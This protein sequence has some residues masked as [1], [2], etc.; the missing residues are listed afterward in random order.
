MSTGAGYRSYAGDDMVTGE[1]V[2]VELP[3]AGVP[4]RAASGVIDLLV[5]AVVLVLGAI[6]VGIVFGGTS[7]AVARTVSILLVVGVTVALPAVVET[8]TRGRTLGKL[9]LGL[10]VVRDDGGPITARHALTRALVGWPEIYLL[11]GSGALV[12]ALVSPRAKRLGDMAAGTY[13]VSQRAS[14]RLLPPPVM[15]PPLAQW[16]AGA[17][18]AALPPGLAIAVRQFLGRAQGLNPASRHELGQALLRSVLPHV[19]PPP[20]VGFHAEHV[21]AA[22]IADRRRRDAERLARDDQRLARLLPPDQFAP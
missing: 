10:R 15:P 4:S 3:I 2:A 11:L 19:S 22:V 7:S 20:P 8:L 13:V 1:G 17:D 18:L 21:L 6:L 12:A 5:A 9:A 14:L 16:A